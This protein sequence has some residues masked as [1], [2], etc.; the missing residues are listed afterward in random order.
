MNNDYKLIA[1]YLRG[2]ATRY[3][4][5]GHT[6]QSPR[7]FQ[8][9]FDSIGNPSKGAIMY[10]SPIETQAQEQSGSQVVIALV[11]ITICQNI[12]RGSHAS[13]NEAIQATYAHCKEIA[14][15]MVED[16]RNQESND[17]C[18]IKS[19]SLDNARITVD[20]P[21]KDGWMGCTLS[22]T[23]RL[24]EYFQTTPALWQ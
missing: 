5:I 19:F 23:L 15:V 4:P 12:T 22:F 1:H 14:A 24:D 7:F 3:I 13:F 8:N 17:Y 20:N 21:V 11:S 16:A 2:L 10:M 6:E 18:L 9:S